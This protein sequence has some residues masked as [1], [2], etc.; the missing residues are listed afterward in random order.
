MTAGRALVRVDW[1]CAVAVCNPAQPRSSAVRPAGESE[2]DSNIEPC[3]LASLVSQAQPH[4]RSRLSELNS[5]EAAA[6]EVAECSGRSNSWCQLVV[7]VEGGLGV[8]WPMEVHWEQELVLQWAAVQAPLQLELAQV[9][10]L[11]CLQAQ[12]LWSPACMWFADQCAPQCSGPDALWAVHMV[13]YGA[14]GCGAARHGH[15]AAAEQ[16]ADLRSHASLIAS[17]DGGSTICM[18]SRI[19]SPTGW[20]GASTMERT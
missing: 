14:N 10:G 17:K 9:Q 11:G 7:G 1:D 3:R 16:H 18:M 12:L 5:R 19:L 20:Y 13:V 15:A 2:M 4:I 8:G 6:E